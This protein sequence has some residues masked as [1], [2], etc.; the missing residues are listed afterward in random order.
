MFLIL[1][2]FCELFYS[3]KRTFGVEGVY[4]IDPDEHQPLIFLVVRNGK[5]IIRNFTGAS[6]RT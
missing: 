6:G 5:G 4:L 2:T 3:V 1:G